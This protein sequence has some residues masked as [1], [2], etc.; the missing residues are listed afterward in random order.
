MDIIITQ[1]SNWSAVSC[2]IY[3]K[4]VLLNNILDIF[5][6]SIKEEPYCLQT[7]IIMI[8]LGLFDISMTLIYYYTSS[9]AGIHFLVWRYY[10]NLFI[11]KYRL[12]QFSLWYNV[13]YLPVF[14]DPIGEVLRLNSMFLSGNPHRLLISANTTRERT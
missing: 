7:V 12:L 11:V 5:V 8:K 1:Q 9:T 2:H 4:A 13:A 10:S 3:R 14:S 6:I